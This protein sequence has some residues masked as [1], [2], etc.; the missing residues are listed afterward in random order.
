MVDLY[1]ETAEDIKQARNYNL[2]RKFSK[3]MLII[4]VVALVAALFFLFFNN[5]REKKIENSAHSYYQLQNYSI[6][7]IATENPEIKVLIEEAIN[8]ENNYSAFILLFNAG[9]ASSAGNSAE[10]LKVYKQVMEGDFAKI[11]KDLAF[12]QYVALSLNSTNTAKEDDKSIAALTQQKA[13]EL[14]EEMD[15]YID[16]QPVFKYIALE[17]KVHLLIYA[18]EKEKARNLLQDII[19]DHKAPAALVGRCKSILGVI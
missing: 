2:F 10:A 14:L 8:E 9:F 5:M 12:L 3:P 13:K 16:N 11:L 7:S 6:D 18:D 15:T 17:M 19:K 4:L 1:D